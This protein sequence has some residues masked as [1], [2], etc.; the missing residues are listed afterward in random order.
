MNEKN[1]YWDIDV[2][3]LM[4]ALGRQIWTI[5]LSGLLGAIIA[6]SVA[7][8]L[9]TS[10]EIELLF[11]ISGNNAVDR[12]MVL[13]DSKTFLDELA[14][15]SGLNLNRDEIRRKI[16]VS[17]EG[18][19]G[20]MELSI[21]ENDLE[22]AFALASATEKVLPQCAQNI[23]EIGELQIID[24]A[25]LVESNEHSLMLW[26]FA[27][28]LMGML[29]SMALILLM[30][31]TDR[32]IRKEED[33]PLPLMTKLSSTDAREDIRKLRSLLLHRLSQLER[34]KS[35]IFL[36]SGKR[37]NSFDI[38]YQQACSLAELGKRVLFVEADLRNTCLARKQ[39]LPFDGLAELLCGSQEELIYRSSLQENLYLL[40]AGHGEEQATE[41]LASD[42]MKQLLDQWSREYDWIILQLPSL[43]VC[44]DVLAVCASVD[45]V[46]LTA[47]LDVSRQDDLMKAEA[48]LQSCGANVLGAILLAMKK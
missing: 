23:P 34:G 8:L 31:Q 35:V 46:I 42:G 38:S 2:F 29:V 6:F 43:D 15:E 36:S 3:R 22:T 47:Q 41:L 33:L 48:E 4:K 10:Y 40:P 25:E 26:T 28:V 12:C 11:Y 13:L 1:D 9:P 21:H 20:F 17:P 24:H 14:S 7:V 27:G 45:A 37:M 30:A 16:E 5:L 32:R 39:K 19:I 44:A 18:Q